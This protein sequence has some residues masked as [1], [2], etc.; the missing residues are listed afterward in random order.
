MEVNNKFKSIESHYPCDNKLLADKNSPKPDNQLRIALP[1]YCV[2]ETERTDNGLDLL[3][4]NNS[5]SIDWIY[6]QHENEAKLFAAAPDM[7][8]ALM[9]VIDNDGKKLSDE[10]FNVIINAVNKAQGKSVD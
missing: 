7:Y 5:E 6:W 10:D 4:K 9:L 1:P 2:E 3:I 8:D